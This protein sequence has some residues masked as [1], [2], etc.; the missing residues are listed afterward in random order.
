MNNPKTQAIDQTEASKYAEILSFEPAEKVRFAVSRAKELLVN[1]TEEQCITI[2]DVI[3]RMRSRINYHQSQK[4]MADIKEKNLEQVWLLEGRALSLW[5]DTFDISGFGVEKL[6]WYQVFAVNVLMHSLSYS[7][8]ASIT[9]EECDLSIDSN[10]LEL[11][12]LREEYKILDIVE[13]TARAEMLEK[14]ARVHSSAKLLG[15]K[16][17]KGR[18][19]KQEPLLEEVIRLY[20]TDDYQ[21]MP[22][23]KAANCISVLIG[24]SRP[25]LLQLTDNKNKVIAIQNFIR[26]FKSRNSRIFV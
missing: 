9:L 13:C 2:A 21:Y 26:K 18:A 3:S 6:E 5:M 17:G 11:L 8:T 25:E 22:V 24:N 4:A 14:H 12:K 1:R 20:L 7:N 23:L 15:S 19:S 16:G 10:Q